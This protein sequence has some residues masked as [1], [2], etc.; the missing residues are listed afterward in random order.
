MVK[1]IVLFALI[2]TGPVFSQQ[3]IPITKLFAK[4]Q[5]SNLDLSPNGDLILMTGHFKQQLFVSLIN[6][7]T[8]EVVE[9]YRQSAGDTI[10]IKELAWL[11]NQNVILN[12]KSKSNLGVS[13]L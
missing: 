1:L 3:L 5:I 9:L 6:P 4:P 7:T 13:T 12:L 2:V 8:E 11:D 10:Q